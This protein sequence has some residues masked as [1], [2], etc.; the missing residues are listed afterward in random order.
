VRDL[1]VK[2]GALDYSQKF[3]QKLVQKGKKFVPQMTDDPKLS[4]TLLKIADFMIERE[5]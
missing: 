1:T 4:D 2:T 5:S 3:S